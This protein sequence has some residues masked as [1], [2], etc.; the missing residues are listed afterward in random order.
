MLAY[1]E[2]Q[3]KIN[4]FY[5]QNINLKNQASDDTKHDDTLDSAR[6]TKMY[7]GSI[8][9]DRLRK[10]INK[11]S[12][13][14]MKNRV[15]SQD[16]DRPHTTKEL[17]EKRIRS[18][19]AQKDS[20]S[21]KRTTA[22]TGGNGSK[23]GIKQHVAHSK[24]NSYLEQNA[25]I[26]NSYRVNK[27][28]ENTLKITEGEI[29]N[30]EVDK[31][32]IRKILPAKMP[33]ESKTNIIITKN[34]EIKHEKFEKKRVSEIKEITFEP[35]KSINFNNG[36]IDDYSL[37]EL[38]GKGSYATVY[39]AR[40]INKDNQQVAIKIFDGD[41]AFKS[42]KEEIQVL[43]KINSIYCISFI[44]AFISNGKQH[45]VLEHAEGMSLL[46]SLK[47]CRKFTEPEAKKIFQ[48]ILNGVQYLHKNNIAHRDLKL[49]NIIID[50]SK[51]VKIIDFGFAT[52]CT[53]DDKGN[54]F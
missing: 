26:P 40:A 46:K 3:D 10:V 24:G 21:N 32:T 18:Q 43:K 39:L 34:I 38:L 52:Q 7:V 42:I 45:I 29:N 23:K 9:G 31:P 41:K 16:D 6:N 35:N 5:N 30:S 36:N 2:T 14:W 44:D 53:K 28:S 54:M 13:K 51:N 4:T 50:K 25:W 19:T 37:I 1:L 27:P 22:S 15:S 12:T 11:T 8:I 47:M 17:E 33:K 20:I 49:E 48:K